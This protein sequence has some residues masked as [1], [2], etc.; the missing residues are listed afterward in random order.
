VVVHSGSATNPDGDV[1]HCEVITAEA[2]R[3]PSGLR[4]LRIDRR[5]SIMVENVDTAISERAGMVEGREPA[6]EDLSP[7][8]EQVE[9]RIRTG[10]TYPPSWYLLLIIAGRDRRYPYQLANSR[11]RCDGGRPGVWGHYQHRS[12]SPKRLSSPSSQAESRLPSATLFGSAITQDPPSRCRLRSPYEYG[13]SKRRR[14]IRQRGV[15]SWT[16]YHRAFLAR[17]LTCS[18]AYCHRC[19]SARIR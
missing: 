2:N 17:I 19:V 16:P 13:R 11:R 14:S 5:G 8:W 9:A 1:V 7:I 10:G 12:R 18:I 6:G 15:P 4:E 3:I